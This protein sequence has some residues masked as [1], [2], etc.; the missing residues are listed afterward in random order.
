MVTPQNKKWWESFITPQTGVML[1]AGFAS[2]V[3]FWNDQKNIKADLHIIKSDMKVM[4]DKADVTDI[5]ALDEKVNR[6]YSTQREMNDKT[7]KEVEELKLWME[8]HKGYEQ[9]IK[10]FKLLKNK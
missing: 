4:Q 3:V 1:L 6:Q 9:A 5:K 7:N 8:Y 10:D 2:L